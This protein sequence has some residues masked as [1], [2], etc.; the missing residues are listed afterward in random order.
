MPLYESF[1]WS[2][3]IDERGL[4]VVAFDVLVPLGSIPGRPAVGSPLRRSLLPVTRARS[5]EVN[6]VEML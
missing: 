4:K 3:R 6:C 1:F 2:V 5:L